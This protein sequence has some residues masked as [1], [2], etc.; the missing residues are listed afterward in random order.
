MSLPRQ[1]SVTLDEKLRVKI[2]LCNLNGEDLIAIDEAELSP[3]DTVSWTYPADG[4]R[5]EMT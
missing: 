5:I 2:V 3:G 1:S 4:V